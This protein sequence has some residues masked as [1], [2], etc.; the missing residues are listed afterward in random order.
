VDVDDDGV[1]DGVVDED[2]DGVVDE[3]DGV[4][5][6]DAAGPG[7]PGGPGGPI[8]SNNKVSNH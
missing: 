4:Q 8:H 3:V 2:D 1:V 6:E 7:G 5:H